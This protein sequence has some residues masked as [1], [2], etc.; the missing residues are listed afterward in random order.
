M[1]LN[2]SK[3]ADCRIYFFTYKRHQLMPRSIQSLINQTYKDWR[4]EVHNDCPDDDFPEKYIK[5]LNDGRFIVKNHST[6]LGGANSFNL[7]FQGC[8]EKYVSILEDDNWWEPE[9]LEQMIKVME[10]KPF[11]EVAWGNM[12][13]W[14]ES[15]GNHW[16]DTGNTVWPE[17]KDRLFQWPHC[18]QGLGALHSIGAMMF[19]S[20]H[21]KKYIIPTNSLL[22]A[23]ELIR[24]RA[25]QHPIFL[26]SNVIANFAVTIHTNR[27]KDH[28]KWTANQIMT[29]SSLIITSDKPFEMFNRYL[30]YHRTQKPSPVS[31]FFLA[32]IFSLKDHKFLKFFNHSD[33]FA[34]GRWLIK[35]ISHL[36]DLQKY[37]YSQKEVHQFLI[38]H[39]QKRFNQRR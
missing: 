24:E 27:S 30:V 6:N 1:Q 33:W 23:V 28:W 34:F 17:G 13:I 4:C 15:Q 16:E 14:K 2:S 32:I 11:L 5:S 31:V 20:C 29:L 9:F 26:H 25:F 39:T 10:Q 36:N 22:D 7:A 3:M 37:L 19:R 21:A 38:S 35:N 18:Q 12:R 8:E